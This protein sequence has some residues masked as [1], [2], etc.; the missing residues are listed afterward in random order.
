MVIYIWHA[1]EATWILALR[2]IVS[3]MPVFIG[4]QIV[5]AKHIFRSKAAPAPPTGQIRPLG[6]SG[7]WKAGLRLN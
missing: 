4:L 1:L 2:A 3:E 6:L 7:S 5:L